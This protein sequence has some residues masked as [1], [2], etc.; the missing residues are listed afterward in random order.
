[1]KCDGAFVIPGNG[2][3]QPVPREIQTATQLSLLHF[4]R[5]SVAHLDI[6]SIFVKKVA[7]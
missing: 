5:D 6:P 7:F 3:V 1:M 2:F 4:N